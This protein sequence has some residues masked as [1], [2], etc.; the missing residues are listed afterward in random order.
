MKKVNIE[1]KEKSTSKANKQTKQQ[2]QKTTE[3]RL[4]SIGIATLAPHCSSTSKRADENNMWFSL[5][6]F[7]LLLALAEK[8]EIK[9]L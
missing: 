2:Q 6:R 4:D 8:E 3:K 9:S 1:K 7:L 5:T